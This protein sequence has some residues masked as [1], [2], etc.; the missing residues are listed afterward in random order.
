MA[1]CKSCA[2]INCPCIFQ[3]PATA[4]SLVL[5]SISGSGTLAN[6]LTIT[7]TLNLSNFFT[8]TSPVAVVTEG[9]CLK[10]DL[11]CQRIKDCVAPMVTSIPGGAFTYNGTNLVPT[12]SVGQVLISNGLGGMSW[13][14]KPLNVNAISCGTTGLWGVGALNYGAA[15]DSSGA[16]VYCSASG[17]RTLPAHTGLQTNASSTGLI[18]LAGVTGPATSSPAV[19]TLNVTHTNPSSCRQMALAQDANLRFAMIGVNSPLIDDM[20]LQLLAVSGAFAT[21]VV[22]NL[23]PYGIRATSDPQTNVF[24]LVR[25]IVL[26]AGGASLV[27]DYGLR[28]SI[29]GA[30]LVGCTIDCSNRLLTFGMTV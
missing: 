21:E 16:P 28:G 3:T 29:P 20:Y 10:L 1:V 7:P 2:S 5:T 30:P 17:L 6:P 12:G 19:A 9:G 27:T 24:A 11:S 26:L 15:P 18:L 23:S 25:S 8:A 13:G 14:P 22:R 4:C